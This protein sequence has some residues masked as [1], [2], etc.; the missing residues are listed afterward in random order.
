MLTTLGPSVI[1]TVV[2]LVVGLLLT[3]AAK[4]L[5]ADID[6][7]LATDIVTVVVSSAYYALARLLEEN[8]SHWFGLLLGKRGA[9]TYQ[10]P[11]APSE[12]SP[13]GAVATVD[14]PGVP[15]GEPVTVDPVD[16]QPEHGA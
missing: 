1:R 8:A 13:T 16:Y 3:Q 4:H 7:G 11:A 10:A 9:P 12:E 6:E 15:E 2:P 5:G 14:T